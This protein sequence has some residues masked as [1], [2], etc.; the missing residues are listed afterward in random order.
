M[1]FLDII[2]TKDS[3]LLLHAIHSPLYVWIL[4]ET[5][6]FSGFKKSRTT[7]IES[8]KTRVYAQKPRLKMLFKNAVLWLELSFT[9]RW[10]SVNRSW[11]FCSALC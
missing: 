5:I 9:Y 4:K 11:H 10:E 3:S 6:L 2:L 8:E 1:E 7:K